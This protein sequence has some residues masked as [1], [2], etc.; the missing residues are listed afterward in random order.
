MRPKR[1][2]ATN[3]RQTYM[4]TSDTWGRRALFRAE[5]WAR[6]FLDTLYHY[7]GSAYLLHEFVVM[8]EH[9]H[10]LIT[11]TGSLERA[12]QMMKGGFSFRAKKELGS[13]MEVWQAGFSDHR[14]RDA[15][16]YETH[17]AYMRMNPVRKHMVEAPEMYPYSSAFP[18]FELDEAPQGLKPLYH[19]ASSGGAEAAPF[20]RKP[21]EPQG[22]KSES[23]KEPVGAAKA[24]PFQ[25]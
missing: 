17:V 12:V 19:R 25:N 14:I 8:P 10:V 16:D 21:D 20:Q 6:L 15:A 18:V 11:P 3:N 9:I 23:S 4:V 2:P 1:E 24:A 22:L 7:R 13:S 5:R